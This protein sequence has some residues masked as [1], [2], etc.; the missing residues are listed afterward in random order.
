MGVLLHAFSVSQDCFLFR[1]DY[2]TE[3]VVCS[4]VVFAWNVRDCEIKLDHVVK[5]ISQ[6]RWWIGF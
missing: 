2:R 3:Q 5:R 1:K 6:T 4:N